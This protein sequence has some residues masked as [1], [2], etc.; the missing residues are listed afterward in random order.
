MST[1][2]LR[3]R[4]TEVGD[5]RVAPECA[6]RL[7]LRGDCDQSCR[8]AP[9]W[10]ITSCSARAC[11]TSCLV[12]AVPSWSWAHRPASARPLTWRRGPNATAAQL[13]GSKL[14]ALDN[15][16]QL[17]VE[18][19]IDLLCSV[20]D[21][22][23]GRVPR[24]P[25]STAQ[26]ETMI[27]PAIGSAIRRCTE[28]FVL[29]LDEV[30]RLESE[31][32]LSVVAAIAHEVPPGSTVVLIGRDAPRASIAALRLRPDVAEVGAVDLALEAAEARAVLEEIGVSIGDDDLGR[33]LDDT[34]GWPLGVRFA[35]FAAERA[36]ASGGR[37]TGRDRCPR[38]PGDRRVHARGVAPPAGSGRRRLPHPIEWAR[39]ALGGVGR[40]RTR[41]Q[42]LGSDARTARIEPARDRSTRSPWEHLSI[43]S[44]DGRGS[45]RGVRADST[46]TLAA[47]WRSE[48]A[49]GSSGPATSTAPSLTRAV[50]ARRNAS[51]D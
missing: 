45:R 2:G 49:S 6:R 11:S 35:G 51:S 17:L 23:A 12:R 27:A 8:S 9:R 3:Q 13:R 20:S 44:S 28:P 37:S 19:L 47:R 32:A 40:P 25:L 21:F 26:F 16:P 14:E 34:E 5:P 24:S 31:V 42:R 46:A 36:A 33:L 38:R 50:P 48:R 29:V 41:T 1:R 30:H 7:G 4:T 10:P 43:A 18:R 39:L 15:D 22:D